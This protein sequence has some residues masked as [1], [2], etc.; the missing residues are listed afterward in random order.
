MLKNY[1][2]TTWRNLS[3]NKLFSGINIFGL[4]IGLGC[5]LLIALYVLDELSYDRGNVNA[6]RIYRVT[7]DAHWGGADLH[8]AQAA[9]VTGP[10][11]KKEFP[12]VE[13]FTRIYNY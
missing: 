6:D 11:M 7:L 3:R 4:A 12:G 9:D 2:I 10:I 1:L 5:F 8:L 13:E